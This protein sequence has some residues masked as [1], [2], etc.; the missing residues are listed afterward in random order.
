MTGV[1]LALI[2]SVFLMGIAGGPHC[3]AMCGAAQ[4][5]MVRACSAGSPHDR[6][7]AIA[8]QAGRIA[9][10]A[11]LGALL[12][13]GVAVLGAPGE[14]GRWLG[15]AWRLVHVAALGFGLWLAVRGEQPAWLVRGRATAVVRVDEQPLRFLPRGPAAAG[16]VGAG[17]AAMPCG[18]LHAALMTSALSSSPLAGGATMAA[19]GAASAVML[20]ASQRLW[21]RL[22]QGARHGDGERR[23]RLLV[24]VAGLLLAGSS[25]WALALDV[26]RS[27]GAAW[28]VSTT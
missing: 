18:L 9:G 13:G 20:F 4:A 2:V 11:A 1:D 12:A 23:V 15:S 24:R 28:C 6:R 27:I 14:S 22:G 10:Y 5:G 3:A 19:F 16:A 21:W 7:H 8:L 25:A 17:W 26:G